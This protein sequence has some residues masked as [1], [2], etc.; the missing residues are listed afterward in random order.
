[1]KP[2]LF[3]FALSGFISSLFLARWGSWKLAL[4]VFLAG[5]GGGAISIVH[6]L[7]R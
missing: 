4:A 1:M 5:F 6:K 3:N 2:W 7:G